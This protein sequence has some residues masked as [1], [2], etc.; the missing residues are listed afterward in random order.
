M[1]LLPRATRAVDP[2]KAY[3]YA[4]SKAPI[5]RPSYF[6]ILAKHEAFWVDLQPML[7]RRGYQLRPRYQPGW[8]P[9]WLK[10]SKPVANIFKHED[11]LCLRNS[12]TIDATRLDGTKV[13][14]KVVDSSTDEYP[15][16]QFLNSPELRSDKCN[17]TVPILDAMPY[18]NDDTKLLM[19]MPYLDQ[20]HRAPFRRVGEVYEA[21]YQYVQTVHRDPCWFNL[22]MDASNIIPRGTH[23]VASDTH[24]GVSNSFKW[25]QRWSVRP[26]QY[27]YIDFDISRRYPPEL[28]NVDL[29]E[30]SR[31]GQDRT[32]PEFKRSGPYNPFQA[33]IYQLRNAILKLID[34]Y[35]PEGLEPLILL[36]NAMTNINPKDRPSL[37]EALK[38]LD[39]MD[40][41]TFKRRIWRRQDSFGDRFKIKYCWCNP[42]V[43]SILLAEEYHK[44]DRIL[45]PSTVV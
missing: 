35:I 6:G 20:F 1:K 32:A 26:I 12:K 28:K 17:H 30:M 44:Y 40:E 7:L 42:V 11:A 10:L 39:E 36:G 8:I 25:R 41:R 27:Y 34:E 45:P 18:P 43:G 15:I 23:F 37:S 14:I 16:A 2:E 13:I 29:K 31:A 22:M 9:S 19:V 5:S 4:I 38:Y 21:V 3:K 33:D 24:D